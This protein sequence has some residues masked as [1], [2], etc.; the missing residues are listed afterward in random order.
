MV[1]G[2]D[3][4]R[5]IAALRFAGPRRE[6][7]VRGAAAPLARLAAL[8]P[9]WPHRPGAPAAG[10]AIRVEYSGHG[11]RIQERGAGRAPSEHAGEVAA[12]Q[13]LLGLLIAS[14]VEQD[15]SLIG[16]HVAASLIGGGLVVMSGDSGAGK[17]SLAAQLVRLGGRSF[18][19]DQLVLRL[20][21]AAGDCG[22]SLA[23][24]HKL[25]LPLPTDGGKGFAAFVETRVAHSGGAALEL[26]LAPGE[27]AGFG[28]TAPLSAL[29]LLARAPG[30][31]ASL[32]PVAPGTTARELMRQG[33]ATR[34]PSYRLRYERSLDAARLLL[35]R[36][37][38]GR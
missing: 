32:E 22:I 28:E 20:D 25:R 29:L 34:V 26:R 23:L 12:A 8:L 9:D 18:G 37:G 27:A 5:R 38:V 3:T 6:I 13:A 7:G 4:E 35:A 2:R 11:Y 36:F 30:E 21:P 16:L 19:D 17:S 14:Y 33:Y 24:P 1:S 31:A 15:S 10:A